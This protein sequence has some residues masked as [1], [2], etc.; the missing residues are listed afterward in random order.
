MKNGGGIN[1]FRCT[2]RKP[3]DRFSILKDSLKREMRAS[4]VNQWGSS[5][6]Y[7]EKRVDTK[8]RLK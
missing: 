4:T 2:R 7:Q 8:L 3:A 6:S 5:G 1:N